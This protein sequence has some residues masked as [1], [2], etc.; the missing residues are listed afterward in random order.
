MTQALPLADPEIA[1]ALLRDHLSTAIEG[2]T[3][4]NRE[5]EVVEWVDDLHVVIQMWGVRDGARHPYFVLL[6]GEHYDLYPPRV[7]FVDPRS[8]WAEAAPGSRYFPKIDACPWFRLHPAYKFSDGAR[9]LVCF[10]YSA[11]YYISSH[12]PTA[13][14]QWRQGQHT[15]SATLSRLHRALTEFYGGQGGDA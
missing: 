6:G 14:Q 7:Q 3:K 15:V 8:G 9:Q 12:S 13:E 10:S 1:A 4:A 11:D 2:A 5:W